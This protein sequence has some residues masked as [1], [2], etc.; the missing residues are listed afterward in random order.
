M[1][2]TVATHEQSA[3]LIQYLLIKD[4]TVS[5]DLNA[6]EYLRNCIV[7]ATRALEN[8]VEFQ[9]AFKKF[10]ESLTSTEFET[11]VEN[12]CNKRTNNKVLKFLLVYIKMVKRLLFKLHRFAASLCRENDAEFS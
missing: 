2:R 10:E 7:T 9:K 3:L 8:H 4:L 6:T 1:K 12:A 11:L 5:G